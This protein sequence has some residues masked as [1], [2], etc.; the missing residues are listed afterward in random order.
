MNEV[1]TDDKSVGKSMGQV[2]GHFHGHFHRQVQ[3]KSMGIRHARAEICTA[4]IAA[5]VCATT[6]VRM[7]CR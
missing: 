5:D 4:S 6:D 1:M 7:M 2:H 3:D